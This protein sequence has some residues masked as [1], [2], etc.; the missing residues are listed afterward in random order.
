MGPIDEVHDLVISSVRGEVFGEALFTALVGS[1]S[2]P[3]VDETL[4][5]L[6]TLEREMGTF[7]SPMLTQLAIGD[8]DEAEARRAGESQAA[9]LGDIEWH[10]FLEMFSSGTDNVL[11]RYRRLAQIC[12]SEQ[13]G[14]VAMLI[15]HEEALASFARLALDGSPSALAPVVEVTHRLKT[16]G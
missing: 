9:S 11:D 14:A 12:P 7:A 8:F 3:G 16:F 6:A 13:A 4:A 15:E 5:T 10:Q 1:W 2:D